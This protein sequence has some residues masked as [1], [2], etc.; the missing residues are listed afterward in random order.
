MRLLFIFFI[1][2]FKV[3]FSF[4]QASNSDSLLKNFKGYK[5]PSN[6]KSLG[7]K[8]W[9]R[10]TP[11]MTDIII[12][13]FG[14]P[15]SFNSRT[16]EL[17]CVQSGWTNSLCGDFNND[18]WM[19]VFTTV[20]GYGNFFLLWDSTKK[21][22]NDTTLLNN[23]TSEIIPSGFRP[24]PVYLNSDNWLDIVIFPGDDLNAPIK[25]ILSDGKGKYDLHEII[26]IENDY[27]PGGSPPIFKCTGEVDDLNGDGLPDI[28]IPANQHAYILWGIPN[29]PYF[30]N[31]DHPRFHQTNSFPGLNN[32]GFGEICSSCCDNIFTAF[33]EDV[34]K[35]GRKDIVTING[36]KFDRV[37]LNKGGGRFNDLN[38][39][40]LPRYITN[41]DGGDYVMMDLNDDGLNDFVVATGGGIDGKD[42][43]NNI[44]AVIQK[45][46]LTFEY[47]TAIIE[48]SAKFKTKKLGVI[49]SHLFSFDFNNDG[50]L[51]IGYINAIWG[52]DCGPYDSISNKGNVLPF[53]SVFIREGNKYV[54]KDFFQ[55]DPYAKSLLDTVRKKFLCSRYSLSKPKFENNLREFCKGDSEKI[56]IDS[57][58]NESYWVWNFNGKSEKDIISKTFTDTGRLYITRVNKEFGCYTTSD[59]IRL[60]FKESPPVPIVRDTAFCANS[61]IS[62][63]SAT[64]L[65]LHDVYWS[66]QKGVLGAKY[67]P[68]P[69]TQFNGVYKFYVTQINLSTKCASP[70]A[71]LKVTIEKYPNK[72]IVKDTMFCLNNAYSSLNA[73]SD[74]GNYLKWYNLSE[75]G[76]EALLTPT[77]ASTQDT[78]SKNYFVSQASNLAN[79]ESPRAKI[80]VKINPIPSSPI[81]RDTFFCQN[82]TADTIRII[83][84]VGSTIVWYGGSETGGT[85]SSVAPKPITSTVGSVVY[86][87]SQKITATGCE[88][89]RAKLTVTT[90]PTPTAPN[91]SRDAD[92]NLVA[93][94]NNVTWYKDGVKITDTTQKIKPTSNGNY[95]ATTTQNGCTSSASANYYYITSAASNLSSD[96]YFRISPNPTNGEIY[97]NYNIRSTKDVYI[98]VFDMS[99]RTIISNRKVTSGNKFNLGSSMKGKYIIQVKDKTGRLLTTE[100]LIKN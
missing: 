52:D 98:N 17:D 20:A 36:D 19:D 59:T 32:N 83:P 67:T 89:P 40:Y 55:Y 24:Y 38:N 6:A 22:F 8:F 85:A 27:F 61:N 93:S 78:S 100:K 82:G 92:N 60:K 75:T 30:E 28:Y 35:D 48:F 88:G 53:K 25:I 1:F 96:E 73:I 95:T 13:A 71:E 91:L 70:Q 84:S 12:Q 86:Y 77:K 72:P 29:F 49:Q 74:S 43:Y 45:Q 33:I 23:Y 65:N 10:N 41:G 63:L 66:D 4:S 76:G 11:I 69:N 64:T 15:E 56:T 80:T 9:R 90:K 51:D 37:L 54:E 50:K 94:S 87:M 62:P 39:I 18:G 81:V 99:G 79:C 42:S 3:I 58:S 46:N 21:V 7:S 68:T 26:T 47:D 16:N 34:N 97:L 14:K 2:S 31:K 5:V 57:I 44:Y